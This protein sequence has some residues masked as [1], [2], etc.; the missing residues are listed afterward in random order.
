MYGGRAGEDDLGTSNV[1]GGVDILLGNTGG[2]LVLAGGG[3]IDLL[4]KGGGTNR[5]GT[6]LV[7]VERAGGDEGGE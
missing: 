6:D 5:G 7:D 4:G 3:G 2:V 1:T